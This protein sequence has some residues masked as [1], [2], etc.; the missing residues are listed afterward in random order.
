MTDMT[1]FIFAISGHNNL[2]DMNR[3][4]VPGYTPLCR[5]CEEG[6]K[7]FEHLYKKSPVF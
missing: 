4:I 7:S 5:F 1:L 6:D 3:I 2:Y